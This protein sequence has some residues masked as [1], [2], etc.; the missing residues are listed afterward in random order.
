MYDFEA[1]KLRTAPDKKPIDLGLVYTCL[2]VATEMR[3]LALCLQTVTFTTLYSDELRLVQPENFGASSRY[4]VSIVAE[5]ANDEMMD[6][7]KRRHG[8]TNLYQYMSHLHNYEEG[9]CF[10]VC[11]CIKPSDNNGDCP[12]VYRETIRISG[13]RTQH[14]VSPRYLPSDAPWKTPTE[15]ELDRL[16][17]Y[18]MGV[19][20]K[21]SKNSLH[22]EW[23]GKFWN[24][25]PG[26]YR[27]SAAAS[28]IHFLKSISSQVRQ[29][30][31]NI[32]L[33]EDHPA[34]ASPACH[35]R[36]FIPFCH[37]NP[38]LLI[39]RRVSLWRNIF[40][41]QN[42]SN[43]RAPKLHWWK[44]TT[45]VENRGLPVTYPSR[46]VAEW[47]AEAAR[48]D[49]PDA[50]TLVFDGDTIPEHSATIFRD[51]IHC[52]SAMQ[53]V[54]DR[55]WNLDDPDEDPDMVYKI[56]FSSKAWQCKGFPDLL[57]DMCDDHNNSNN[58]KIKKCPH[59]R[60]NFDPGQPW[61][62]NRITKDILEACDGST[63]RFNWFWSR[64][65]V[66]DTVAPL[67]SYY[68]SWKENLLPEGE[69]DWT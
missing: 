49:I 65:E 43:S 58:N 20:W 17:K 46:P 16:A 25:E 23:H 19:K 14:P 38:S 40:L 26:K 9:S 24:P 60:C 33:C 27:F 34:V 5:I 66:V 7:I 68:Q 30:I 10:G 15:K 54:A 52:G 39:K 44:T 29:H 50:A 32:V 1:G 69:Q 6:E 2:L 3:G 12:S 57:K 11:W 61:D 31:R 21:S 59:I 4:H 22:H 67:P 42:W 53:Q 55:M 28:A 13:S 8:D 62:E 37:E 41:W 18:F 63:H 56:K 47:M 35:I 64:D 48:S 45:A 36:G 51:V